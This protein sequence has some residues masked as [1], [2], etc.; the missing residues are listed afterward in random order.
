MNLE[1]AHLLTESRK[2]DEA[3]GSYRQLLLEP[4]YRAE[5]C[6]GLGVVHYRRNNLTLAAEWFAR[7]LAEDPRGENP[8]FYLAVISSSR[9]DN[10]TA[11]RIFAMLLVLNPSHVGAMQRLTAIAAGVD[12]MTRQPDARPF[13]SQ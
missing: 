3:E 5:A 10:S 12:A 7:S 8:L 1:R 6:Y 9:G 4:K 11:V 2:F 13:L